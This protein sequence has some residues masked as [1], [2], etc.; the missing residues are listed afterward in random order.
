MK[1]SA[2]EEDAGFFD[3]S[4]NSGYLADPETNDASEVEESSCVTSEETDLSS[5]SNGVQRLG[6]KD[7]GVG[8][9]NTNLGDGDPDKLDDTTKVQLLQE[10]FPTA[11]SYDVSH[12]VKKCGGSWNRAME[13]LLNHAFFSD[14]GI[15]S[16]EDRIYARG[17]EAFSEDNSMPRGRRR[18]DRRKQRMTDNIHN[19]LDRR[20]S[21]TPT[22]PPVSS[23]DKGRKD[24]DFIMTRTGLSQP[25]ISSLHHRNGT[26]L[27]L[28]IIALV[29]SLERSSSMLS[30]PSVSPERHGTLSTNPTIQTHAFEL[31]RD[32]P[33]IA[34]HHLTGLIRLTHPSTASA[35]E[36]AKALTAPSTSESAYNSKTITPIYT[37][38]NLSDD[39]SSS[40]QRRTG[41]RSDSAARPESAAYHHA[42]ANQAFSSASSAYRRG[43]SDH[44][45]GAAAGYYSQVGRD[46]AMKR[47][48]AV[49]GA[50]DAL[51]ASQSTAPIV[52]L[53][54][55]SVKDGVRI[56]RSR[57]EKWWAAGGSGGV[58]GL[59]GRV[60]NCDANAARTLTI[61]TGL[62][63]HSE[64]GKGRLGPAV[65]SMLSHEGWQCS[66]GEGEIT[67]LGKA[68]S[69]R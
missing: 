13:E 7:G 44:L 26:S 35:H 19:S 2:L 64:G 36:L 12:T 47:T 34:P 28:T 27:P 32:F 51:V 50:A 37:P 33:T 1:T 55:V 6:L 57:V 17:V 62:G 30:M 66:F 22:A 54:G 9:T 38:V 48:E 69:R 14:E 40:I 3:P 31:G 53:H 63:R 4:G 29:E 42:A 23:W 39:E 15:G 58:K 67:V 56:A 24:V 68:K 43:K 16:D 52:D 5:L 20:A 11:S 8:V 61:V 21:S 49:A 45:M 18:K 41:V 59:D 46:H 25:M 65:G 10:M 60:S